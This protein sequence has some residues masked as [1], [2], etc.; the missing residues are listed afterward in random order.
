M[1]VSPSPSAARPFSLEEMP[2]DVPMPER[3]V[4]ERSPDEDADAVGSAAW[5]RRLNRT[6]AMAGMRSRAG[7]LVRAIEERRRRGIVERVLRESPSLVVDVGCEDGWVAEAYADHVAR[8]VLAD[9]DGDALARSSLAGRDDVTTVVADALAPSDL[10]R[11][12]GEGGADVVLLGALLEHLVDPGAAL[13]ALRPLL[14]RGGRFVVYVPADGPILF[15]KR[16]LRWTGTGRLIS[17][18][19][20]DPAPGHLHRFERASLTALL[21]P[22][23]T[24]EEIAFDPLCLG[25]HAV[26][27]RP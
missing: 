23:G 26:V 20:L 22:H 19:S 27:R 12:V 6:H 13:D 14:R 9:L 18:L 8:V 10:R 2:P 25:Y 16:M 11:V 7:R 24:L 1:S 15:A 17:G 5:N 3:R 4:P 21:R